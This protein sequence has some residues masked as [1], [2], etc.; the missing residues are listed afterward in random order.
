MDIFGRI[1]NK[2]FW[3]ARGWKKKMEEKRWG[4]DG[5][6]KRNTEREVRLR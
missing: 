3:G 1:S 4:R 2:V 6:D 5:K